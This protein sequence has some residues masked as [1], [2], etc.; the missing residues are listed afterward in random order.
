MTDADED[1]TAED[2]EADAFFGNL[3][4]AI[5][6]GFVRQLLAGNDMQCFSTE[7]YRSMYAAKWKPPP[8][9]PELQFDQAQSHLRHIPFLREVSPDVWAMKEKS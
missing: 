7:Q 5:R 8:G 2:A 6:V 4:T 3:M 1:Y 9:M